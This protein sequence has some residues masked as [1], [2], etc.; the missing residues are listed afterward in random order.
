MYFIRHLPT[1]TFYG[2]K[3]NNTNSPHSLVC[4]RT[5]EEAIHVGNS[6]ASFQCKN[7]TNPASSKL[8]Y[9]KKKRYN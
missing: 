6:I 8:C 7:K 5:Y 1:K 3:T 2:L 9:M 4:F